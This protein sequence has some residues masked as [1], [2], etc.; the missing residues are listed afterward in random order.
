LNTVYALS[1]DTYVSYKHG[2]AR[3]VKLDDDEFFYEADALAGELV[4]AIDGK[5]SV[6]VL[7]EELVLKHG[8]EHR[9]EIETGVQS[10][11]GEMAQEGIIVRG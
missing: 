10:I 6:A 5:K 3:L 1:G 2:L 7:I 11:I 8:E 9:T 4:S